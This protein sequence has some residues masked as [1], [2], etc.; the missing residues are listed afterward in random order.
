MALGLYKPGQ[1]YWVRVMTASMAGIIV[2]AGSAWLW[3]QLERAS[4]LIPRPTWRLT[5]TPPVTGEPQAGQ[6]VTLLGQNDPAAGAPK[7]IG[8]AVIQGV[9]PAQSGSLNVTIGHIEVVAGSDPSDT[10]AVQAAA[11]GAPVAAA[12]SQ[13]VS[14]PMFDPLYLQAAGVGV[15]MLVG[16]GVTYWYTG[17]K[18]RTV[19]FLI[20]TD[21]EMKKVNWSTRKDVINSTW[22]V[23]LWSVLL[24]CTLFAVDTLFALVFRLV[25]VLQTG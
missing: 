6:A 5:L 13:T 22:V 23:L 10:K 8:K 4:G 9:V 12:V 19:D 18:P 15:L 14:I 2:L 24:A 16:A 7:E 3:S 25:G 21:G 1:G 11:G 17:V 20:A